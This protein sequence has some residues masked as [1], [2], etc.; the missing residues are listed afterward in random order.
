MTDPFSIAAGA[1]GIVS[2]AGVLLKNVGAFIVD[3][4]VVD[5]SIQSFRADI[6]RLQEV[7]IN[8]EA[9]FKKRPKQQQFEVKHWINVKRVLESCNQCLYRLNQSLPVLRGDEGTTHRAYT[10][11]KVYVKSGLVRSLQAHI[12]SYTQ[13]LQISLSTISI[14]AQWESRA[15]QGKIQ[16]QIQKLSDEIRKI[17]IQFHKRPNFQTTVEEVLKEEGTAQ[18]NVEKW[19]HSA[20]TVAAA[21]TNY[22]PD[23][24]S[25]INR[26]V[27]SNE[28]KI[29]WW[30]TKNKELRNEASENMNDGSSEVA[31]SV[32]EVDNGVASDSG[33]G[34]QSD[35]ESDYDPDPNL[36]DCL[37]LAIMSDQIAEFQYAV[38][39]EIKAGL[40]HRAEHDLR[41]AIS[42]LEQ[43][44]KVYNKQFSNRAAL[45][46]ML[47][48]IL[49]K[50]GTKESLVKAKAILK[51]LLNQER[52]ATSRKWRLYN[53]LACIYLEE[54]NIE[55][56]KTFAN[57]A[58]KGRRALQDAP[59]LIDE[60][61]ELV[62]R[63]YQQS[64]DFISI[65]IV[66]K[67]TGVGTSA[68]SVFSVPI[69]PTTTEVVEEER[70]IYQWLKETGFDT[71]MR[72]PFD[73]PN[74]ETD[75]T[76]LQ[77]A[78]ANEEVDI[79]KIILRESPKTLE[80][81]SSDGASPLLLAATTRN[82]H[83]VK[84]L[85][86][87]QADTSATDSSDYTAL[88]RAQSAKGG[89]NVAE[90]LL[91]HSPPVDINRPNRYG[92]SALHLAVGLG[93][94]KMFDLLL[95][96]SANIDMQKKTGSTPLHIAVEER[97]EDMV[98][99]LLNAK[100]SIDIKDLNGLDVLQAAKRMR[101][102]PS[103]I[104]TILET[105]RK[106]RR[107]SE[108]SNATRNNSTAS[109]RARRDTALSNS[110]SATNTSRSR[111]SSIF[112]GRPH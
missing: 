88:H 81:R 23:E 18:E 34:M 109:T 93:N 69:S 20:E 105:T 87:R 58:L 108:S 89:V 79:V 77:L 40:Y 50:Q 68:S 95:S 83:L 107:G 102:P 112:M 90:L 43:R 71:D 17:S 101:P 24:G 2:L 57:R 37:D 46:E 25:I 48:D 78:I 64:D 14:V 103:N 98:S 16:H 7:L 99:K 39:R 47:A 27:E 110:S 26:A 36:D 1:V 76:P 82:K 38:D 59:N 75:Q 13:M 63:V 94:Q 32:A 22:E 80:T 86:D 60:S 45:E 54:G 62:M 10:Q 91:S 61:A 19:I 41:K 3:T 35:A 30:K 53:S 31:N 66:R 100:A 92:E 12:T 106:E 29:Q 55:K 70:N 21:M 97:R 15:S 11:L 67:H 85:L 84:L 8:V 96:R 9:S 72:N 65:N 33:I 5:E 44:E 74:P 73:A 104:I 6:E 111:I 51:P 28:A 49:S 4:S 56:A 42:L 52:E